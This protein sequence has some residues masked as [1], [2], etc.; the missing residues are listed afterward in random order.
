MGVNFKTSETDFINCAKGIHL[1][2]GQNAVISILNCGFYNQ[3]GQ[4]GVSYIPATF[5]TFTSMFITNNSWNNIGTFFSGFDYTLANGRDANTFIQNNAGDGDRS[6]SCFI[7]V[8]NSST[9]KTLTSQNTWYV[10]NW[11]SNTSSQTCKWTIADNKITYQPTNSRNG[12][13]TVSGNL[14]VNNSNQNISIGIVKN[15]VTSTIYGETTLRVTALI[16]R[17]S[18]HLLP[19]SKI[20]RRVIILKSIIRMHLPITEL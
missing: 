1:L 6:P 5:T 7:N 8:L 12:V 15:G 11:G 2:S 17:S 9:T 20:L 18:F 13:F 14:S 19:S 4:I 3:T 10:A 16:S